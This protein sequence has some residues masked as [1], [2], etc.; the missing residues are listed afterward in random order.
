MSVHIKDYCKG[1]QFMS[2]HI[3]DYCKTADADQM[4][5]GKPELY[6]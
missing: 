3:K 6:S 2:V 4:C 1:K 5:S